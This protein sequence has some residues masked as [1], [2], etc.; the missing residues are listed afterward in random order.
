[1]HVGRRLT[2][3]VSSPLEAGR[4]EG[5][6]LPRLGHLQF[7]GPAFDVVVAAFQ[8][9]GSQPHC[10]GLNAE[11]LPFAADVDLVEICSGHEASCRSLESRGRVLLR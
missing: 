5:E 1:M 7:V 2:E 8:D 10:H 11:H 3:M 6:S 4:Q 9:S